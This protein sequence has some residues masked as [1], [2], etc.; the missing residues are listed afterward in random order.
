MSESGRRIINI[1]FS[2]LAA[3]IAWTFVV[4]NDD[5]MTEVTYRDIPIVFEGETALINRDLGVADISTDTVDVK[6]RQMRVRTNDIS[7]ENIRVVADVS[8]A[9]EGE[10]GISLNISGPENTQ[11]VDASTRSISVEVE[12]ASSVEKKI[13][14]EYEGDHSGVEP[15]VT[16]V[17]SE[18]ATVLGAKS[19]IDRVYKIAALLDTSQTSDKSKNI[20]A[21]LEAIDRN[22]D[23]LEHVIIYPSEVNFYA[24]TG[25]TKEVKLKIVT[26]D[27]DDNYVRTWYAPEKIVIKGA[28][29]L[30][31]NIDSV[32]TEE[33][34]L[35]EMYE[36][37]DV[38]L[39]YD[40]PEGIYLANGSEGK[41]I[42]I[43][44]T[45]KEP[46]EEE[47]ESGD[48]GN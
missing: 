22:G 7:A 14:I 42:K 18:T 21:S 9:V 26:D 5:P 12:E 47:S 8:N 36:N 33:I 17:T 28:A 4:Y 16:S 43:R 2:L 35:S 27:P 3:I 25:I 23:A 11:V 1:I 6:L 15:V 29:D 19:E 40:L 20:T 34:E 38:E 45:E 46:E 13:V 44:V 30:V 10:N 41:I 39:E 24:Y 31:Q 32:S 37:T 48:T